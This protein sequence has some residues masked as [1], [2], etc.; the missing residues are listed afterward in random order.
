[1]M[2]CC[3][4]CEYERKVAI[5]FCCYKKT[6]VLG[7]ADRLRPNECPYYKRMEKVYPIYNENG[8]KRTED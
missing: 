7:N 5:G 8:A 2:K 4:T 1:M 6:Q 3:F